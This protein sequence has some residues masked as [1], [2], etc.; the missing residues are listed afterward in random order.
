MTFNNAMPQAA[1]PLHRGFSLLELVM[2]L[3]I[4]AI[5]AAIATPRYA[6]AMARYR[7]DLAARRIAADLLLAQRIARTESRSRTVQFDMEH[8]QYELIN[9]SNPDQPQKPY[10]V[11]LTD[12]P[13]QASQLKVQATKHNRG[14]NNKTATNL[15]I[16]FNGFGV[17]DDQY[18]IA[19]QSGAIT[20]TVIVHAD[21][22][23]TSIK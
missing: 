21:T 22:G 17:P 6:S 15:A 13:Y 5:L 9:V 16:T 20:R 4:I 1:Q 18:T 2:V 8:C 11:N 23:A 19:V 3:T 7:A 12:P 10:L 14:G